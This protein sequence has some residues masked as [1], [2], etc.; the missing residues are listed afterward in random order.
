MSGTPP[1]RSGEPP[2]EGG[3][4]QKQQPPHAS[5]SHQRPD[6]GGDERLGQRRLRSHPGRAVQPAPAAPPIAAVR[7]ERVLAAA[8]RVPKHP[9]ALGPCLPSKPEASTVAPTTEQ[10]KPCRLR[11]TTTCTLLRSSRGTAVASRDGQ[12]EKEAEARNCAA[13]SVRPIRRFDWL[14]AFS[15]VSLLLKDSYSRRLELSDSTTKL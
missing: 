5:N 1:W 15:Q 8:F 10:Q 3:A 12:N 7:E 13:F 6:N 9:L 11:V 14:F 4:T 2:E